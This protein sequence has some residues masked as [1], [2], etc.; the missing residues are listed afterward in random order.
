MLTLV[1]NRTTVWRPSPE[2]GGDALPFGK[3]GLAKTAATNR[4]LRQLNRSTATCSSSR[5]RTARGGVGRRNRIE[6]KGIRAR[7]PF[8]SILFLRPTP[9]RAVRPRELEHVAVLLLSCLSLLLVAAVFARPFFPKGN[10]SPPPSGEGRQTVVLLDTSV[11][12]RR[13]GLW[14][15]A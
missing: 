3:K 15:Q 1:S 6:P 8:G 2:G 5:G 9:P 7:M 11:S 12:M 14:P 13:E 10:A 4:R